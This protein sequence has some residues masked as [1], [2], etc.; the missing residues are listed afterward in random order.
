MAHETIFELRRQ[1]F[2]TSAHEDAPWYFR[3]ILGYRVVGAATKKIKVAFNLAGMS[4]CKATHFVALGYAELNR[5]DR[6][7]LHGYKGG[8]RVTRIR[9][10][11]GD[12][13]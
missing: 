10:Q 8:R 1:R 11:V 13:A 7:L 9:K 5:N 12:E 6:N 3:I 2:E 4:V